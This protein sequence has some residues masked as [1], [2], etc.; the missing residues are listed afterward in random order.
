MAQAPYQRLHST[1]VYAVQGKGEFPRDMM[2]REM[3]R[4]QTPA[5]EMRAGIG[6]RSESRRVQLVVDVNPRERFMPNAARWESFGWKVVPVTEPDVRTGLTP[7]PKPLAETQWRNIR[8]VV[9]ALADHC[10][11][12]PTDPQY[13]VYH[14]ALTTSLTAKDGIGHIDLEPLSPS[15]TA[16]EMPTVALAPLQ[17]RIQQL[18]RTEKAALGLLQALVYDR[19]DVGDW[20]PTATKAI[21]ELGA[22]TRG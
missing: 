15:A 22:A 21:Q 19:I 12:S 7:T 8:K 13:G 10:F 16:P 4:F 1:I 14:V 17:A 9:K 3:S 11:G 5:D 6:Y 2:R 18:E 20:P